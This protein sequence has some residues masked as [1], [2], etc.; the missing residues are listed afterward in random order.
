MNDGTRLL[1]MFAICFYM[2]VGAI[3]G[4]IVGLILIPGYCI[5]HPAV[6]AGWERYRLS[7]ETRK[8]VNEATKI[9]VDKIRGAELEATKEIFKEFL[10]NDEPP[11]GPPPPPPNVVFRKGG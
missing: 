2:G 10:L 7:V 6:L 5:L 3:V 4:F 11:I 8:R 9:L 1:T